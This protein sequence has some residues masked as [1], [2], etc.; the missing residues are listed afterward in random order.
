VCAQSAEALE[1]GNRGSGAGV[2]DT[3]SGAEAED[4]DSRAEADDTGSEAG[5]GGFGAEDEGLRPLDRLSTSGGI[6]NKRSRPLLSSSST[7]SGL[8]S[9]SGNPSISCRVGKSSRLGSKGALLSGP[10]SG[11]VDIAKGITASTVMVVPP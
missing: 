8:D 10:L 3:G 9:R 4:T 7:P 5:G 11:L 2:G 1:A 6:Q